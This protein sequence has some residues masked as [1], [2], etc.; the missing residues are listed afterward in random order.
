MSG[1]TICSL[2]ALVYVSQLKKRHLTERY[3]T[4]RYFY[5]IFCETMSDT[6]AHIVS[7]QSE[8]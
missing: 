2:P 4:G 5:T 1:K 7:F 3:F 6:A 8:T